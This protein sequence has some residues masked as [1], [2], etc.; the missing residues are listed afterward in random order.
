MGDSPWIR[1]V[2]ISDTGKSSARMRT[3]YC[4]P[5]PNMGATF[6]RKLC[7]CRICWLLNFTFHGETQRSCTLSS[8]TQFGP[9]ILHFVA[10]KDKF[11]LDNYLQNHS[12]FY[13]PKVGCHLPFVPQ[14]IGPQHRLACFP[15]TATGYSLSCYISLISL[16]Y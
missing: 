10:Q 1:Q 14:A 3:V 9:K 2:I 16:Y 6:R 7:A 11:L 12:M 4:W 5:S 8:S 13:K 15:L